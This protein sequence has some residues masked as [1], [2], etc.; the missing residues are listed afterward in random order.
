MTSLP[1]LFLAT[2]AE[3]PERPA[4]TCGPRTLSYRELADAAGSLAA[5]L[6][7]RGV[8]RGELVGVRVARSVDV[9]V[10]VLGVMLAGAAYVPLDPRYPAGRLRLMT[11]ECRISHVV[12]DSVPV[13]G[14]P[15]AVVP[16]TLHTDDTAYVIY[17]SG[18][19]GR[20]KGCVV[21]HGNVLSL[22]EAALP[23][24]DIGPDDRWA[25][26]H[27]VNFDLS[28]WEMW[29][30]LATGGT[31]VVVDEDASLDPGELIGLLIRE[32]VTVLNQV[33]SVFRMLAEAHEDEGRPPLPLRYLIFGGDAV[34]L[35]GTARFLAGLP[36][37]AGPVAVNMYGITETTVHATF[38]ELD[39]A[40]L[41]G[42]NPSPI[43][44]PLPNLGITLRDPD[45]SEVPDGEAG[46]IWVSGAGVAAGYL[47]RDELTA[48][49]FVVVDGVRHYRSGDLARR[50]PGGELQYLSRI[51]R[52][53]KLRGMRIELPEIE[54]VLRACAGVRDAAVLLETDDAV[55]EL[56]VA[57]VAAGDAFDL[58]RA[59]AECARVLPSHMVPTRFERLATLPLSPSGKVDHRALSGSA[60]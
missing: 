10:A 40:T 24:F 18:S 32:R 29:G 11:E 36:P 8:G 15:P 14:H 41:H 27:S 34:D 43:G 54:V 7:R 16:P 35:E 23:L 50:V 19:T 5:E 52:Q 37:G 25:L 49:R 26:F 13:W 44:R 9:A 42:A 47:G 53:V 12:G 31:V 17:T 22:L 33:P 48:E 6:G 57:Y 3:H 4:V 55:G 21:T 56:L 1:A 60:Q 58:G 46:E 20:P 51:D 38:K 45:G 59:R 28:V 39:P 2:C 30:A